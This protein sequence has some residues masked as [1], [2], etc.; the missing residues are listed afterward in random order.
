MLFG[1]KLLF[2][3]LVS[4]AAVGLTACGDL[5]DVAPDD[6]FV[7][8]SKNPPL[9]QEVLVGTEVDLNHAYDIWMWESGMFGGE[10]VSLAFLRWAISQRLPIESMGVSGG[11][12][13][14]LRNARGPG[15]AWYSFLQRALAGTAEAKRRIL[16]GEFPSVQDPPN[17]PELAQVAVRRGFELIWLA[18]VWCDFVLDGQPVIYESMDGWTLAAQNFEEALRATGA[19]TQDRQA[20]LAGLA[21]VR[22]ILLED[23]IALQYAQQVTPS[24]QYQAHYATTIFENTNRIWFRSWGF[25][26]H[27]IHQQWRGL[28]LDN[29]GIPDPRTALTRDPVPPRGVLDSLWAPNKVPSGASPLN[30]TSGVEAQFIVAELVL[31]TDPQRTV[32]IINAVRSQRGVNAVWQPATLDP[33]VILDK[34]IDERRRTLFLE[35]VIVHDNRYWM[36]RYGKDTWHKEIPQGVPVG[37][38]TC[39][40]LQQREIDNI[41]GLPTYTYD[42]DPYLR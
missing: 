36:K 33:A 2:A 38:T 18:D 3:L 11:L 6:R 16:A 34:L 21:R 17:S 15:E 23:Q 9:L 7:D 26:E 30:V 14:G 40:P 24:F 4:V 41:G 42:G 10:M 27:G 20:A 25:G 13:G 39:H 29:T 35:G 8:A 31:N 1:K 19:R 37:D 5:L 32:D 22:R 12:T 28:T